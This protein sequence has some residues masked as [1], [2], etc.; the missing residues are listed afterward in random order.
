MPPC[1]SCVHDQR[2]VEHLVA[3]PVV[4]R[5]HEV[6]EVKGA[7]GVGN[8]RHPGQSRRALS[9][10]CSPRSPGAFE[11]P[12]WVPNAKGFDGISRHAP[13]RAGP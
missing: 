9:F 4:G 11:V 7:L 13:G 12:K 6:L 8:N 10:G 1:G 5:G 3:V 2:S